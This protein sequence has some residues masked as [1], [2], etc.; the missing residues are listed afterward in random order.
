MQKSKIEWT[1]YSINP[2][3]GLCP[4]GCDYCYARRLYKRFKW[5]PALRFEPETMLDLAVVPEGGRVFIGSTMELFHEYTLQWMPYII[6]CIKR[7][8]W[9]TSILLTKQPQNL[10]YFSPF[11]DNCWVGVTVTSNGA[12]SLALTHLANIKAG[13]KIISFEPLLG[14]IGMSDHMSMNEI[15]DQAIIG[16]QTPVST[17]TI[18]RIE[19][20]TDIVRAASLAGIAVF[21]KNNMDG[22]IPHHW[23][24]NVLSKLLRNKDDSLRQEVP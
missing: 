8:P 10:A 4:M 18:P 13:K 14:D 17:R 22:I 6:D 24:D 23:Q 11:P 19:W 20:V 16:Q 5:N 9:Q 21:I 15:I 7:A 3:K 1:D 12:M 2:I